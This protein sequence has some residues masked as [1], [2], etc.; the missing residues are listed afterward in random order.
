MGNEAQG[1]SE[2]GDC[3]NEH[4]RGGSYSGHHD[5]LIVPRRIGYARVSTDEQSLS[6]Q[7]DAL[8]AA[9]CDLIF[10]EKISGKSKRLPELEAALAA[11]RPHDK[12]VVF[13]LDRL[14]RSFRHLVDIAERIKDKDAYILSITEGIS[15]DTPMGEVVYRMISIFADLEHTNIVERTVA[16]LRAT[17]ARG[18]VLGRR[19]K[20]TA[21]QLAE[22]DDLIR[23]GALVKTLAHRYGVNPSTIFR[24]RQAQPALGSAP[25]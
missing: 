22:I 6:S 1:I 10:E 11:L 8:A 5:N 2:F 16:G 4:F 25:A 18:Q 20:L 14:G 24:A 13:K 12:I 7:I 15:T 17:K 3:I 23:D 21:H 9:N 19:P